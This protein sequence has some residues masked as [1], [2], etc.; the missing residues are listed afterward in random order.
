MRKKIEA[1]NI[2]TLKG[3]EAKQAKKSFIQRNFA[4]DKEF[5]DSLGDSLFS[6]FEIYEEVIYKIKKKILP[7][8]KDQK[9]LIDKSAASKLFSDNINLL[10]PSNITS[11]T[12]KK[13]LNRV[14]FYVGGKNYEFKSPVSFFKAF[15]ALKEH[16]DKNT[17]PAKIDNLDKH[18]IELHGSRLYALMQGKAKHK[19]KILVEIFKYFN[20]QF[21]KKDEVGHE[22]EYLK[23][24]IKRI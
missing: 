1:G 19:R 18:L 17:F 8:Y 9:L 21:P 24:R 7:D 5:L 22:E 11:N 16:F 4:L 23:K 15:F 12:N 3:E 10:T 14:I 20:Y 13:E 2:K 6:S